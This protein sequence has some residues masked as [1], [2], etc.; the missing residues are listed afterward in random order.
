MSGEEIAGEI[1]EILK[2]LMGEGARLPKPLMLYAKDMLFFDGA[3]NQLAP[4]L[5]MLAEFTRIYGYFAQNHAET[6]VSQIGFDPSATEVDLS[7]A[8]ATLGLEEG[9][10]SIT[11]RELQER[12]LIVQQ[13]LEEQALHV[14]SLGL[15]GKRDSE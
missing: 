15:G 13:K 1:Q 12:R 8:K 5:D 4:E 10:D 9:E 7:I 14:P 6:I 3:V 2:A 11:H